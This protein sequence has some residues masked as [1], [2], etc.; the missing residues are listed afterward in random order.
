MPSRWRELAQDGGLIHAEALTFAFAGQM[1]RPQAAA[2]VAVLIAEVRGGAGDL[3]EL[4]R[5]RW[6]R[7]EF[8]QSLDTAPAETRAFSKAALCWP[9]NRVRYW[10]GDRPR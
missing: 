9:S 5:R 6:P 4:A 1:P 10:V 7:L 3:L 2:A 8:A